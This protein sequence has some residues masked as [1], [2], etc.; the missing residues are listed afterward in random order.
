[1]DDVEQTRK[2]LA[3]GTDGESRASNEYCL[4]ILI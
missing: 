1:M 4:L 2:L 3:A